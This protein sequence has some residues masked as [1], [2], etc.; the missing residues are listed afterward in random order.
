[1]SSEN[2]LFFQLRHGHARPALGGFSGP[3]CH[4]QGVVLQVIHDCRFER[5]RAQTVNDRD[6]RQSTRKRVVDEAFDLSKPLIHTE[7][8]DIQPVGWTILFREIGAPARLPFLPAL[9]DP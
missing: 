6:N 5:S 3:D 2:T 9:L 7:P 1:M 8:D 4:D